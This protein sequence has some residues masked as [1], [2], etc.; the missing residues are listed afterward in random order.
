MSARLGNLPEDDVEVV[1][2][3]DPHVDLFLAGQVGEAGV[4]GAQAGGELLA[5]EGLF[6]LRQ[7]VLQDPDFFICGPGDTTVNY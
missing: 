3:D 1:H 4:V 6:L 5:R 7:A 2:G